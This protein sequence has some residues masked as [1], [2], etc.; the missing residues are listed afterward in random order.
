MAEFAAA[1][2]AE[3]A[4]FAGY[5]ATAPDYAYVYFSN[6]ADQLFSRAEIAGLRTRDA[7]DQFLMATWLVMAAAEVDDFPFTKYTADQRAAQRVLGCRPAPRRRWRRRRAA[8]TPARS[9]SSPQLPAAARP[10]AADRARA[11]RPQQRAVRAQVQRPV[12]A[13][14][15]RLPD[16]LADRLA[17]ASLRGGPSP[18]RT[19]VRRRVRHPPAVELPRHLSRAGHATGQERPA[20]AAGERAGRAAAL[21]ARDVAAQDR[22]RGAAAVGRAQARLERGRDPAAAV[23]DRRA[24]PARA[25][26]VRR[27]PGVRAPARRRHELS[28]PWARDVRRRDRREHPGHQRLGRRADPAV[29][30]VPRRGQGRAR[31][32]ADVRAPLRLRRESTGKAADPPR[33]VRPV[34]WRIRAHLGAAIERHRPDLVYLVSPNNPTGVV[35]PADVV[36]DLACRFADTMYVVDEAYFEFASHRRDVAP[37]SRPSCATSR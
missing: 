36:H 22:A 23:G 9:A 5:A 6:T 7:V 28:P 3:L 17:Q 24:R 13:A 19:W 12:R 37:G 18:A 35:W 29:P 21:R 33:P 26:R 32:G 11:A 14:A 34:R 31:A 30:G 10:A 20:G 1:H 25:A 2:L 15:R 16:Q 8:T 4:A 27:V